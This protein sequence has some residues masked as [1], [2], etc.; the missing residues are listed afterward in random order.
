M[1][2]AVI[3][4]GYVGL[5]N[6]VLLAQHNDVA[7]VEI[8]PEKANMINRHESPIADK[9]IQEYLRNR[10]LKLSATTDYEKAL[11]DAD[12]VIIA[13]PINYDT[14]KNFFDTSSVEYVISKV[15]EF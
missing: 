3:G 5:S 2:I 12:Y 7:A 13:T 10:P 11:Q 15:I 6:A 1:K 4:T 14:K 8:V 9:D